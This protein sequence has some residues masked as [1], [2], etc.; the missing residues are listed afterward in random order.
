M[1]KPG[2]DLSDQPLTFDS[3]LTS[4][5]EILTEIIS[6]ERNLESC[7]SALR[8]HFCAKGGMS[9]RTGWWDKE[10]RFMKALKLAKIR[11]SEIQLVF[12]R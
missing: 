12:S 2:L 6:C 10:V 5:S 1:P 8:A 11:R 3:L 7:D 4:Y 9:R